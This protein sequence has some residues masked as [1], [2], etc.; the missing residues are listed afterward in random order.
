M[1]ALGY[2]VPRSRAVAAQSYVSIYGR[3]LEN[4]QVSIGG[5]NLELLYSSA[6]QINALLPDGLAGIVR[7]TVRNAAGEHTVNLMVEP[8]AVSVHPV[9]VRVSADYI[10][11]YATGMG[12]TELR[13]DGLNWL[14]AQPEVTVGGQA[15]AV[16]YA[17]RTPEFP[18]LD[19]I[20]C[21]LPEGLTGEQPL[22][23]RQR[24]RDALPVRV[25]L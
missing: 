19:Q 10:T 23:V 17:G 14:L 25:A 15:C 3:N 13:A 20:N 7:I 11:I 18:G 12:A 5:T 8:T 1:P 9:V 2:G 22:V 24:G 21:R 4:A 16:T 6:G